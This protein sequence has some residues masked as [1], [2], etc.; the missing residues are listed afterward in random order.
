MQVRI[1][2]GDNK[3]EN[4]VL[5]AFAKGCPED[6]TLA[7][8][9]NYQPSDLAVVF[10]TY[11][12]QVPISYRRGHVVHSQKA[13]NK[14]V[15]ILE[16]GYLNR[17]AGPNHHYSVGL[18]GLNGRA[19]FKNKNSPPDRAERFREDMKPWRTDGS[20]ILLCGQVPWDAS[21]DH[22]DFIKWINKTAEIIQASSRRRIIYRPH[23]LAPT[24]TPHGTERSHYH[25]LDDDL[26]NCWCCVTFNSNSGVDAALAGIPVVAMDEGSMVLPIANSIGDINNPKTPDRQQ[27]LN[28]LC[29]TQWTIPEIAKGLAWNQLFRGKSQDSSSISSITSVDR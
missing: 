10:G 28:N 16:T 25:W 2:L 22:I 3:D 21:V 23:P 27:W 7:N 9:D 26:A 14:D 4:A 13:A 19:D 8:L 11:K 24:P 15:V 12:K 1:Y 5:S 18:N 29:Y 17:G 6:T 20:H